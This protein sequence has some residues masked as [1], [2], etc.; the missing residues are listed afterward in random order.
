MFAAATAAHIVKENYNNV[1][2]VYVWCVCVW[3][4][5]EGGC[6]S[7][8]GNFGHFSTN[9]K[10]SDTTVTPIGHCCDLEL[11]VFVYYTVA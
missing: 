6:F 3:G 1:F 9:N 11:F 2:V 5:G 4:V 7:L 10:K 8:S